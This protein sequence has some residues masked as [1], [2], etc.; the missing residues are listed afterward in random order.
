MGVLES[1][2]HG[3]I[4]TALLNEVKKSVYCSGKSIY[5]HTIDYNTGAIKFYM[6][7]SFRCIRRLQDFYVLESGGVHDGL[8][9]TCVTDAGDSEA[10][11]IPDIFWN[12]LAKVNHFIS[13]V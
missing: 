13:F 1:W 11:C 3:G 2:R 4:A 9:F 6:K 10:R 8:L 5:L 12:F 7:N